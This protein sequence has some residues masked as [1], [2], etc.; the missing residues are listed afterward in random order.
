MKRIDKSRR[1]VKSALKND[2][3]A[4]QIAYTCPFVGRRH[5]SSA[6][7]HRI[8]LYNEYMG[9]APGFALS[10]QAEKF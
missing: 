1:E 6:L 5:E 10:Q 7:L 9:F 4:L 3:R 2:K 8:F